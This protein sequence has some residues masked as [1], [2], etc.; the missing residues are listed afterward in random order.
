MLSRQ[1]RLYFLCEC[2][3]HTTKYGAR[4]L[5]EVHLAKHKGYDISQPKLFFKKYGKY[6]L[7][8][9]NMV[10]FGVAAAGIVVPSLAHFKIA[11][12][13]NSVSDQLQFTEEMC[14]GMVDDSISSIEDLM[15]N[16]KN[17]IFHENNSPLGPLNRI[18]AMEG[19]EL[20][21]LRYFLNESDKA[22]TL[23]N[24]YKTVTNEGRVKWV[25]LDHF[26]TNYRESSQRA[27]LANLEDN[28]GILNQDLGFVQIELKSKTRAKEFYSAL[29]NARGAHEL[30]ASLNWGC[31]MDDFR[32]LSSAIGKSVGVTQ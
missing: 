31:T 10:K 24:L 25:C 30:N 14:G 6:V 12:S 19:V 5:D 16:E 8:M 32:A 9:L 1:F 23:G 26:R 18:E 3:N 21:Q 20:R 29:E 17:T 28:G 27:F 15:K 22:G 4:A 11:E 13:L 7:A 2:G